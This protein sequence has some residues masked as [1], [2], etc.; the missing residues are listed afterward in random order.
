[1][2]RHTNGQHTA[3]PL[4]E[5]QNR[6]F[7]RISGV[8]AFASMLALLVLFSSPLSHTA[9]AHS[10]GMDGACGT[11][12]SCLEHYAF[13]L[14]NNERAAA[15]LPLYTW[16]DNLANGARAHSELW[17]SV[18]DCGIG[19]QCPGE[20]DPG[21]RITNAWGPV[22]WWGENVGMGNAYPTPDF[23]AL[24]LDIHQKF[25]AEGPSGDPSHPS[26]YDNIMSSK[27][28]YLGVGVAI[29]SNNIRITWDFVQP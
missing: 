22:S 8:L 5:K 19:H 2:F 4:A 17:L 15:G 24:I 1:M 28:Q 9:S 26:H 29:D 27:F 12:V 25:M 13:D 14:V 18:G 10:Y 3:P 23:D 11:D 7:R 16:D 6:R 20:D 21:T